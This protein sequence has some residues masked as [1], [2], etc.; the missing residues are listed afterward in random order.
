VL[1]ARS[2]VFRE[3]FQYSMDDDRGEVF[4]DG[5]EPEVFEKFLEYIYANRVGKK[6]VRMLC[7]LN[8]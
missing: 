4:I 7:T 1:A 8:A 2:N 5:V 3:M 6:R